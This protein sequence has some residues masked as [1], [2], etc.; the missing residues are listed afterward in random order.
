MSP[1]LKWLHSWEFTRTG[2]VWSTGQERKAVLWGWF[3]SRG[4]ALIEVK[5]DVFV[6]SL[7]GV[8]RKFFLTESRSPGTGEGTEDPGVDI[9]VT[10][11]ESGHSHWEIDAALGFMGGSLILRLRFHRPSGIKCRCCENSEER[12]TG[13]GMARSNAV[14]YLRQLPKSLFQFL[15]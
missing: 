8:T 12:C 10:W 3:P 13:W 15:K 11:K 5:C 14:L 9:P 7:V 2:D 1:S 6:M 4:K